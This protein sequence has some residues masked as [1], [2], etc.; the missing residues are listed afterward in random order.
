MVR[1]NPA[2]VM[3]GVVLDPDVGERQPYIDAL[4]ID[5]G[6]GFLTIASDSDPT[7]GSKRLVGF[8]VP[9]PEQGGVAAK[10]ICVITRLYDLP[11]SEQ[12]VDRVGK[13]VGVPR[14]V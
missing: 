2:D 14:M 1:V 5:E 4:S 3:I 8:G 7:T 12:L 9:L 11:L 13:G 6:L 10:E